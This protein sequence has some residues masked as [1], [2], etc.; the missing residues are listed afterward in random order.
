M[1]PRILQGVTASVCCPS[2]TS[3]VPFFSF[4]KWIASKAHQSL[5]MKRF[6]Y[7]K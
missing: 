2:H 7:V 3:F 1:R 5:E 6:V 4:L